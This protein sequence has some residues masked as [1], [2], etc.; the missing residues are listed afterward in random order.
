VRNQGRWGELHNFRRVVTTTD[1][2]AYGLEL[3]FAFD[4][5]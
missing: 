5:G 2:R 4:G 3:R 1:P